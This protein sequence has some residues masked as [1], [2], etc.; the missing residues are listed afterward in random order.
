MTSP[1]LPTLAVAILAVLAV[2]ALLS[3]VYRDWKRRG[4]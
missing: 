3:S 1:Y 2:A 4:R